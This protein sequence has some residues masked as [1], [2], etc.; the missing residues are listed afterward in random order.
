MSEESSSPTQLLNQKLI[1]AKI[2]FSKIDRGSPTYHEI[3]RYLEYRI[4]LLRRVNDHPADAATT[5]F[6]RGKIADI[7]DFIKKCEP[8]PMTTKIRQKPT[9]PAL[10][11]E[12]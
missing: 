8:K 5:A 4:D 2:D 9:K 7:L 6:N 3:K 10:N 1:D 11:W 12:Q